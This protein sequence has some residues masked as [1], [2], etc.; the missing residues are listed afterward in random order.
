[1]LKQAFVQYKIPFVFIID[2]WDCIFRVHKSDAA[3]QKEYLDFLR[4]L[5]K[6]KSY[7]ALAYMTGILPI[8]K[9]GEHS[10]INVFYEYSMTDASPIEE[11]TGFTEQ[12]VRQLCE[13]Y[14]MPFSETK[15]W[16]DGYRFGN[17]DI[18]C[19]WDVIN[20]VDD[21][22]SE[23]K[24]QPKAYWI[25]SSGN[26]LVKRF[27]DKA[28]ATTR[29]EIEQL[30]A[31]KTVEKRIRLDLTYDEIDNSIDNIWSVLFTTGYLTQVGCVG[32]HI[33][34]L[35]ISH[36]SADIHM[37]IRLLSIGKMHRTISLRLQWMQ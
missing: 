23:A 33:Y 22:V 13:H 11:F 18:Y 17:T 20:Y 35:V 30:I 5:L 37:F 2:E 25:N 16:Y 31:E 24:S 8:K 12:E 28:D 27:I 29:D 19:P 10:A 3:S 26:D 34:Q 15:K 9:Y 7:I 21:L 14:N 4:N 36:I 1:M 32:D 6:D